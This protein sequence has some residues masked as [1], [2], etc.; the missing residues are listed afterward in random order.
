MLA[1][2][3]EID[4]MNGTKSHSRL[5]RTIAI[6]TAAMTMGI[7]S[8]MGASSNSESA[9]LGEMLRHS[10]GPV[11]EQMGISP[12]IKAALRPKSIVLMAPQD[13]GQRVALSVVDSLEFG[14]V[15]M[16]KLAM[17]PISLRNL[18]PSPIRITHVAT[19]T[20]GLDPA[21]GFI[22][23][24]NKTVIQP[25]G[26]MKFN[27][28]F[29]P[30]LPRNY[31]G[32]DL[33]VYTNTS[34]YPIVITL[35]GNGV[36]NTSYLTN[37]NMNYGSTANG[38]I[39]YSP[40]TGLGRMHPRQQSGGGVNLTLI[41]PTNPVAPGN[42]ATVLLNI[43]LNGNSPVAEQY[44]VTYN[45]SD[46]T[47]SPTV[48]SGPDATGAQ[49]TVPCA[50]NTTQTTCL[51]IGAPCNTPPGYLLYPASTQCAGTTPYPLN[52]NLIPDSQTGNA[53]VIMQFTTNSSTRDASTTISLT[54]TLS[55]S[56]LGAVIATTGNSISIPFVLPVT[57]PVD[58]AAVAH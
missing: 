9:K 35:D 29:L 40:T 42:V 8:A 54:S 45:S 43:S 32:A 39:D 56:A 21:Y 27:V 6:A 12:A 52:S 1:T 17:L 28:M 55:A 18:S 16:Y 33:Y 57:G 58:F 10:S 13:E 7:G 4:K 48:Y 47:G 2:N 26:E 5:Q 20:P 49:K 11:L 53:L 24:D 30:K 36:P 34:P 41:A 46:I 51:V 37:G 25:G 14:N 15:P 38:N 19:E 50:G 3:T 31:G 22:G 23:I 44:T